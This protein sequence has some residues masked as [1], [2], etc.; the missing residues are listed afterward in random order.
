MPN[1]CVI[2]GCSGNGGFRFPK[3][4]ELNLKW[5]IAVKREP[6][7]TGPGPHPTLWKPSDHS[8]VCSSHFAAEDFREANITMCSGKPSAR[9]YFREGAVPSIFP[10]TQSSAKDQV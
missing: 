6:T 2:K 5:R 1:K 4:P 7:T 9:R 10:S 8:V 3:D